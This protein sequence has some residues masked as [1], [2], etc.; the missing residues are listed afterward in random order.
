MH[1]RAATCAAVTPKDIGSVLVIFFWENHLDLAP[2]AVESD[3]DV[4]PKPRTAQSCSSSKACGPAFTLWG[5][6]AATKRA[7]FKAFAVINMILW[8]IGLIADIL[9]RFNVWTILIDILLAYIAYVFWVYAGILER[10]NKAARSDVEAPVVASVAP[11]ARAVETNT[12]AMTTT[13]TPA[14]VADATPVIAP[15]VEPVVGAKPVATAVG[16]GNQ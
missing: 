8:V 1:Q 6:Y 7:H 2:R 16:T 9:N 5:I 14:V 11:V 13:T 15:A 12:A 10:G 3:Q 4:G